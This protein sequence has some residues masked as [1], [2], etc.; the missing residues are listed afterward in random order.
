V[1]LLAK[2]QNKKTNTTKNKYC[3]LKNH[4]FEAEKKPPSLPYHTTRKE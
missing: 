4:N 1:L 2:K 3:Q